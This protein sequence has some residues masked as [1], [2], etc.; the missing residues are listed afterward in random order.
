MDTFEGRKGRYKILNRSKCEL[1][2]EYISGPWSGKRKVLSLVTHNRIQ[3]NLEIENSNRRLDQWWKH[4]PILYE[5]HW[6][7]GISGLE[8]LSTLESN[9]PKESE[10]IS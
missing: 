7:E 3:E 9:Y 1:L 5:R 10:E 4:H 8:L 6:R 2:V